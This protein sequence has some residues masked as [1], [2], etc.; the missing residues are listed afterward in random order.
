MLGSRAIWHKGFKAVAVHPSAPS[1][2]SR[3][4]EDRW[5]LY[6]TEADRTEMHDLAEQHPVQLKEL[7]DLWYHAAGRYHGLPLDDRTALEILGE[8]RP[9]L[10]VPRDRYVY[11]AGLSEVPEASAVNIRNRSF[12]IAAEVD[13]EEN[14]GGVVFAHGSRFGGHA[15]YLKTGVLKYVTTTSAA[16]PSRPSRR[17]GRCRRGGPSSPPSSRRTTDHADDRHAV[18]LRQRR[19]GRRGQHPDPAGQV[20]RS[21]GEGLNIGRDGADPVTQDYPGARPW[22]FS[23]GTIPEVVIDVSGDP[24][25]DLEKE[26]AGA[27]MRD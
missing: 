13:I 20:R 27:F 18:A 14:A 21:R 7:V 23:G 2:W 8:D 9:Q 17:P 19:E 12:T 3:F 4:A 26:A 6:N 11:R 16:S 1:D 22:A 10:T 5:E 15:L 24:F 25:I